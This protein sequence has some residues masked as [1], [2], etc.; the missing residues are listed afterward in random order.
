MPCISLSTL[1]IA[2]RRLVETV[3]RKRL[4]R[5]ADLVSHSHQ[6]S[7]D[8]PWWARRQREHMVFDAVAFHTIEAEIA[9]GIAHGGAP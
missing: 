4:L 5:G 3:Q 1:R 7:F 9:H 8:I 6:I 2:K